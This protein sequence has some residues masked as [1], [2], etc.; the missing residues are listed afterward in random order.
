MGDFADALVWVAWR[1][2]ERNSR[3]TK[4]PYASTY[5]HARSND[6]STWTDI[7]QAAAT[8]LAIGGE[9]GIVLGIDCGDGTRLGGVD[10]DSCIDAAGTMT[11]WARQVVDRLGSYTERSPSLT[12]AKIFFRYAERDLAELR[13][14][15]GTDHGKMFKQRDDGEHPPAIELHL[16][17]R[18]FAVTNDRL[19]DLSEIRMVPRD[20]LK[21]IIN[22]A[23]PA[24]AGVA[25]IGEVEAGEPLAN[26]KMNGHANN[27][28][29]PSVL[30]AEPASRPYAGGGFDLSRSGIAYRKAGHIRESGIDRY[31]EF[32]DTM[33]ADP[34]TADWTLE[35]GLLNH[36]RELIRLFERAKFNRFVADQMADMRRTFIEEEEGFADEAK[37]GTPDAETTTAESGTTASPILRI[38]DG[39][40]SPYPEPLDIFGSLTPEP[41]LTANMLPEAIRD[42]AFDAADRMGVTPATVAMPALGVCAAA[43]HGDIKIQP[44]EDWDWLEPPLLWMKGVGDPGMVKTPAL[45]IACRPLEG[46]DHKWRLEDAEAIRQYEKKLAAYKEKSRVWTHRTARGDD[47]GDEP[48]EPQEPKKRWLVGTDY[49]MEKLG[50]ILE[51]NPRSILLK[52]DELAGFTGGF[53]AYRGGKIGKDR[54]LALKLWDGGSLAID[55]I[56][57]DRLVPNWAA[58]IVGNIQENKLASLAPTLTDDGLMQR[59][60]VYRVGTTGMGN[61]REPNRIALERYD[62]LIGYLVKLEPSGRPITLSPGAQVV[63]QEVE[64]ITFAIKTSPMVSPALRGH[65]AK[66]NGLFARLLLTVH[67]V[68]HYT[69][70]GYLLAEA[71]FQV[72]Q[73][74]TARRARDLLV[75]F[76]IPNAVHIYADYF[77]DHDQLGTDA[78]YIAGYILAHD[79][80]TITERDLYRGKHEFKTARQ[81]ITRAIEDLVD[82]GWIVG[83]AGRTWT[84]NPLVRERFAER[85]EQEKQRRDEVKAIIAHGQ[86]VIRE[87][88]ADE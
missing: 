57:L 36:E 22:E 59:F 55:R 50:E 73:P 40:P 2:E 23:G 67:A 28:A 19:G 83:A 84:V 47:A 6:A 63:Q 5:R 25:T 4:V 39:S 56:G 8:A 51:A 43:I 88:Y 34:E 32:R 69:T 29:S 24:L 76:L 79:A 81:R 1:N 30:T 42:F 80:A 64:R 87:A 31:T 66:L 38:E 45:N 48:D 74:E 16:S 18:Y 17:S 71:D 37:V 35:K 70:T 86:E 58:G 52:I 27:S 60:L 62:A 82:A 77:S 78:R 11:R 68:E 9:L 7:D 14:L 21:W 26:G 46:I 20:D 72:V 10:L 85:A 3:I 15:M 41:I 33:I 65:A 53:D 12:G 61:H 75:Q 49:T 44:T 54:P 13:V